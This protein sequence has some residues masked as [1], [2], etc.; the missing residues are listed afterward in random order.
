MKSDKNSKTTG[1]VV[2]G[3]FRIFGYI[4]SIGSTA[5]LEAI[6]SES[7]CQSWLDKSLWHEFG[8]FTRLHFPA[9]LVYFVFPRIAQ[10]GNPCSLNERKHRMTDKLDR[11]KLADA[12]MLSEHCSLQL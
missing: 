11:F 12:N 5:G 1:R 10:Y 9:M 6:G 7:V 3:F 8:I 4:G 2:A